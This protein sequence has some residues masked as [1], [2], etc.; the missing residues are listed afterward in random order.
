MCLSPGLPQ[1]NRAEIFQGLTVDQG[2]FTS[3]DFLP[4]VAL[5]SKKGKSGPVRFRDLYVLALVQLE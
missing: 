5:A 1:A 4:K 2:F 3:K